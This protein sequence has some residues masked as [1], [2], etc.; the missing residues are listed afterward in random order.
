[1]ADQNNPHFDKI[2]WY[3]IMITVLSFAYIFYFSLVVVP[4]KNQH[5][6]D[7]VVAFLLGTLVGSGVGYLLGGNPAQAKKTSDTTTDKM[8]VAAENV[9]VETK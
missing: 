1:M 8:D 2:Y 5:T 9:N 3:I 7:F 6:V 4:D